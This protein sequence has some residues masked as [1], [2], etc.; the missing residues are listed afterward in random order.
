MEANIKKA[1]GMALGYLS[2]RHRSILEMNDYLF[3]KGFASLVVET[4]VQRLLQENYLNDRMFA[5][6][7]LEN[8]K[9]NKPKSLFAFR[10]EL[11]KKGIS[12]AIIDKLIV[13]YDDLELAL[14]AVR[15]KIR[16]WQHL[17]EESM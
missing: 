14:L 11:G 8:R 10:Y 12:P 1:F 4:V 9:R 5:K 3:K 13:E 2:I 16:L 7:Y 15:K 17:D 6:N